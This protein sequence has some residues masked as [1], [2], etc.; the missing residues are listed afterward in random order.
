VP[1]ISDRKLIQYKE[2]EKELN[3]QVAFIVYD[4]LRYEAA[5]KIPF[6]KTMDEN[7]N[8]IAYFKMIQS[9]IPT[10]TTTAVKTMMTGSNLFEYGKI[11][12]MMTEHQIS[13]DN[14]VHQ[15]TKNNKKV[16]AMGDYI[17]VKTY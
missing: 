12:E 10:Y 1:E 13:M 7:E 4:S 8:E 15:L 6:F 5:Q 16:I 3:T 9:A 11:Y 14:I 17:W 2:G